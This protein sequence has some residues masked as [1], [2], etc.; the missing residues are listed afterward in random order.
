V[1]QELRVELHPKG[2]EVVTVALDVRPEDAWPWIDAASP[3]HPSLIDSS[4]RLDEL[5]GIANVPTGV[6]IDEQGV[7]VRPP[8]V[9]HPGRSVLRDL[10]AEHGI[11]DGVPS[12]M[13]EQAAE[14]GKIR[15]HP[16]RYAAAL[17]D[18]AEHGAASRHVLTPEEVVERSRSRPPEVSEAAAHFELAQHLFRSGD[19]DGAREHFRAAHRLDPDNWTYK[20]QAWSIEDPLQGPTE[21][22][23]SDW[24]TD[25]RAAGAEAYYPLPDLG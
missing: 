18:W 2:V 13:R 15:A 22:Y 17:R 4:H 3:E 8:E 24:L 5:L 6:W 7:L 10:V 14:M 20:R 12:L 25:V 11:P 9:A 16:E 21:H 1:W 23:D 19:V